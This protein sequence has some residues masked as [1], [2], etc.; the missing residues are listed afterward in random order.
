MHDQARPFNTHC[1]GSEKLPSL[2]R[3]L[4]E[5]LMPTL[6]ALAPG[7]SG[8]ARAQGTDAVPALVP[9]ASVAAPR[10]DADKTAAGPLATG[11]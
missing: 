7:L 1:A 9:V 4:F 10:A 8:V 6:A 2:V 3:R 5:V 11:R